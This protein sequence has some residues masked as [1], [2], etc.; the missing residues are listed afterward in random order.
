[1]RVG[2]KDRIPR[3]D[4]SLFAR[5]ILVAAIR[6]SCKSQRD[7]SLNILECGMSYKSCLRG[8]SRVLIVNSRA[9]HLKQSESRRGVAIYLDY[10][11]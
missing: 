10:G 8:L 7:F 2:N 4:K 11:Y 6:L 5:T 1:M 3:I 9:T